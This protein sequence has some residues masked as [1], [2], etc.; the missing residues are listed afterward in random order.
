MLLLLL[1]PTAV[2][3][4]KGSAT[5]ANRGKNGRVKSV[6]VNNL[7]GYDTKWFHP[8]IYISVYGSRYRLEH[9]QA[10][11]GSGLAANA[12]VSPGF[13]VGFI[14]DLRLTDYLSLRFAPGVNPLYENQ[15]EFLKVGGSQD[16]VLNQEISTTQVTFPVLLKYKSDRRRNTRV[17]LIGGIKPSINIGQ[18]KREPLRSIM[19]VNG[20]DFALE[21]GVG[22]DLFY[23]FF[24]FGPELR[25]SHGL[26]N[27]LKPGNDVY[28]RSFQRVRSNSVTLYLNI[29]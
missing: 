4:Q 23:P 27:L 5:S 22:L 25:F 3:A 18:R 17:Y 14:G 12:L 11:V 1:L 21:Y 2:L 20:S 29:E 13:G 24:K 26:P 19:E 16:S 28:T 9:S 15:V 8:G 10:Y 6:T 7:P